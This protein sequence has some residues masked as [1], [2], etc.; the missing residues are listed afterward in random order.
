MVKLMNFNKHVEIKE[1]L[2]QNRIVAA[3]L[4]SHF[5]YLTVEAIII[6]LDCQ[7][8][9]NYKHLYLRTKI[10]FLGMKQNDKQEMLQLNNVLVSYICR[11]TNK[12]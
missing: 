2:K 12:E 11:V 9:E 6:S 10:C 8:N 7:N 3:Q 4:M 5:L 1:L